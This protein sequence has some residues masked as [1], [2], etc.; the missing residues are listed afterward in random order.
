MHNSEKSG[1]T[2]WSPFKKD[3]T[4][5]SPSEKDFM[6]NFRVDNLIEL[7]EQLKVNGVEVINGIAESEFGKFGWFIDIEGNKIELWQP[8]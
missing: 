2:V 3:T 4:Y 8:I 1:Y 7:L 5:F 6:I